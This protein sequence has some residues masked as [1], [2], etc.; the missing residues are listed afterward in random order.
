MTEVKF[1]RGVPEQQISSPRKTPMKVPLLSPGISVDT[2]HERSFS[3]HCGNCSA[4]AG[5]YYTTETDASTRSLC[6]LLHLLLR[7]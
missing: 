2:V 7:E 1:D 6:E 5:S 3:F 4:H